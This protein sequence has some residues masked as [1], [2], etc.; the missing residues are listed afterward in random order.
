MVVGRVR[1]VGR[2][3]ELAAVTRLVRSA[4]EG[5]SGAAVLR[6]D[7]GIGKSA[8]L[9]AAAEAAEGMR[10]LR[11]TGVGAESDLPFA[12]LHML[13]RP[14][15][16]AVGGLPDDQAHTLRS[17]LGLTDGGGNGERYLVGLALLTLLSDLAAERPLLCLVDDAHWLDPAS[18][19]VLLFAARRLQ[20]EGIAFLFAARDGFDAPG[21]DEVVPAALDR[22]T[23]AALLRERFPGLA[24]DIRDRVLEESE[25]N[26]LALIEL[27]AG[28][29]EEQRAG[30]TAPPAAFPV[31]RRVLDTLGA[32]IDRLPEAT[33][34]LL[35]VAAAE[36]TG[37]LGVVLQAA[38]ALGCAESDLD[39]ADRVGLLTLSGVT[40]AFR[41]PLVR[42][43]AYQACPPS[44]R[45]AVHRALAAVLDG[46]RRAL[47]LAAAA[48]GP[49]DGIARELEEAAER[50]RARGAL[51]SAV[52]FY[53][54]AADLSEDG[55][56][57]AHRLMRAA[58]SSVTVGR[59][60]RARDLAERADGLTSDPVLL[61]GTAMVLGTVE[62]ERGV[63]SKA[64]G[65]LIRRAEPVTRSDPALAHTLLVMAADNA[66]AAGDLP[67]VREAARLIRAVPPPGPPP[68]DE[69][70][71]LP[72]PGIAADSVAGLGELADDDLDAGLPRLAAV[73]DRAR[74]EPPESLIVRLHLCSV[75]LTIGDD[76]TAMELAG[77]DAAATCRRGLLGALPA[78]LQFQA[79]GQLMTGR[80]RDA[81]LSAEEARGFA[82]ATGKVRTT[83]RLSALEAR[84]AAIAGDA[85]RCREAAARSTGTAEADAAAACALGLL[86]LTT[87]DADGAVRH[88]AEAADGPGRLTGLAVAS[89]AD[90]VEAAVL[91]GAERAE[92]DAARFAAWAQ[93][94]GRPWA[95]AL[96][97]RCRA[98]L[99]TA[100][101]A[102]GLYA[103]ALS[104]HE[105]GGRPF[106]QART[107]LLYGEW[108]RRRKRKGEA[109][110]HL[111]SSLREFE[112][113]GAGPWAD[114][115]RAELRAA[116]DTTPERADGGTPASLLTPQELQIAR[117]AAGGAGNREIASRLFLSHRTVEYHL[118]KAYPK[119]GVRTRTELSRLDLTD[120]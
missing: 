25:G 104:I 30:R 60:E 43:A 77:A 11:A 50:A 17:A 110:T 66:W 8:L 86:A 36:G 57:R 28:L 20:A 7:A 42:S 118:Y 40:V 63:A 116:G 111:R 53:E 14:V 31:R 29:S 64:A 108:L 5:R 81:A 55:A 35:A 44:K 112:R 47:Q 46:D 79:Q 94:S 82:H 107:A 39:P 73:V 88:L 23:A 72:P 10:V 33:R 99:E 103:E 41:H 83:A 97:L 120:H 67:A 51:P 37:E 68:G 76:E 18:S 48:T 92:E 45:L 74:T 59:T 80:H 78:A 52:P 65:L 98:L 22:P 75:A 38:Q 102:G 62:F 106:E 2:D 114:R 1:L 12:A 89:S 90:L 93:A 91:S 27:P 87:G 85:E 49:D 105:Q 16:P 100:D 70:A 4:R 84:A 3:E 117:M 95:R 71:F 61:A 101:R 58:Q 21:L 56:Q 34:L 15:L 13:L 69:G 19:D 54:R 6:G 96:A 113:L 9:D 26:P 109:R 119:L 115:A 24:R 32:R